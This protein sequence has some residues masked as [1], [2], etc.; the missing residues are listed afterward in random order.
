MGI[1]LQAGREFTDQDDRGAP[2]VVVIN[3]TAARQVWP[4]EDPVRKQIALPQS[5]NTS[6]TLTVAGVTG[7]VRQSSLG[8]QPRPEIFLDYMQS[9]LSWTWL[10][11][12][13]RTMGDPAPTAG[14]VKAIAYSV[15]PDVP[16]LSIHTMDE[17][18]SRSLAEPR[19]YT[20]LLGIFALLA[21]ALAA[22]GLYGVISYNVTERTHEMGIRMALGAERSQVLRLVIRQGLS[23]SAGGIAIG[24]LGAIAATRILTSLVATVQPGDP[25]T[26]AAIVLVLLAVAAA[27]CSVPALRAMGVDPMSALRY[28]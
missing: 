6:L 8:S 15:D 12:A 19:V 3:E 20:L 1:P 11:M 22:V 18:L 5:N 24:V 7:D 16:I 27:A 10:A 25:L 28:E 4:G 23:L 9:P 17:V 13:V 26:L 2:P 21:V 14:A